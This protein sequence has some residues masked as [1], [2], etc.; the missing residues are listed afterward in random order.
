MTLHIAGKRTREDPRKSDRGRCADC[1]GETEC[2][3]GFCEY[4]LGSFNRCVEQDCLSVFD[5]TQDLG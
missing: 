3:Y 1:G 4:G 2:E 5:F